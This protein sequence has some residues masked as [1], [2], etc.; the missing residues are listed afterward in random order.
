MTL[1]QLKYII[2]IVE[3]GSIN[4]AA[5]RLYISQPSLSKAVKTL[6]DE[7]Q[8]QIF[9]RSPH[10]I[11]LT[12]EGA[13]F[14][15]YARQVVE[16]AELLESRY[17]QRRRPKRLFSVSTQHYSFAVS[18]FVNLIQKQ[19]LEEYE[20][21]LRETRTYEIIEDVR[22]ARSEL[23]VIY[24][25]GFNKTVIE[26]LL[27]RNDLVF[28]PVFRATPHVFISARH[29]LAERGC[30]ELSDLEN[31]PC[32][33]FEQGTYNSFYF[34]EEILSTIVHRKDIHV[35]DRATLFNLLIGVNG[36][37]ICTGVLSHD[38]N[39]SDIIAV[40]LHANESMLVGWICRREARLSSLARAYIAELNEEIRLSGY[41]LAPE[42][43]V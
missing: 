18:A 30:I 10:G 41:S 23:G 9:R 20:W 19:E 34:A 29:P 4:E 32:L 3:H 6:E 16:Q 38:F 2:G 42:A 37:T 15:S 35:S 28:H 36:Y 8:V 11:T 14:L 1:Q 33:S 12:L 31:Y 25:N 21:T 13:E 43:E 7:I 40:P 39:G 26:N 24:L 17:L 22:E 5:K 27:R